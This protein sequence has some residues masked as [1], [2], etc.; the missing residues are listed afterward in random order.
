[1]HCFVC[2]LLNEA[3]HL[4]ED[5]VADDEGY[6]CG[7][8]GCFWVCVCFSERSGVLIVSFC[9]LPMSVAEMWGVVVFFLLFFINDSRLFRIFATEGCETAHARQLMLAS[10]LSLNRSFAKKLELGKIVH[11]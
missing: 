10:L 1:M 3:L 11:P 7:D 8:A 2:S 6:G 4:D 5:I 9:K